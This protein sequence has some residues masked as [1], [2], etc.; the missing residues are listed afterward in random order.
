MVDPHSPPL[1]PLSPH[2]QSCGSPDPKKKKAKQQQ[3]RHSA[4]ITNVSL[5]AGHPHSSQDSQYSSN[6]NNSSD[7]PYL[8][9]P[10]SPSSN[11]N[12]QRNLNKAKE[13]LASK[14]DLFK[15]KSINNHNTTTTTN[16]NNT[17][18]ANFNH[19]NTRSTSQPG[20][21]TPP[22]LPNKDTIWKTKMKQG[23]VCTE[24]DH[25][26]MALSQQQQSQQ[27][28][29]QQCQN[30]PPPQHPPAPQAQPQGGPGLAVVSVSSATLS[31]PTIT[32]ATAANAGD[33]F[34]D[35]TQDT[36]DTDYI[37]KKDLFMHAQVRQQQQKDTPPYD[38]PASLSPNTYPLTTLEQ[39]PSTSYRNSG[40]SSKDNRL[41]STMSQDLSRLSINSSLP[42]TD[43][44]ISGDDLSLQMEDVNDF[45]DGNSDSG[46]ARGVHGDGPSAK[47]ST[48]D[49]ESS[50]YDSG[51][52]IASVAPGARNF[53]GHALSVLGTPVPVRSSTI[54]SSVASA[55]AS[56]PVVGLGPGGGPQ[57]RPQN[58]PY[59]MVENKPMSVL[60]RIQQQQR[61]K[62][63]EQERLTG[64]ILPS[65]ASPSSFSPTTFSS[66]PSPAAS[67]SKF[68]NDNNDKSKKPALSSSHG[69]TIANNVAGG[70]GLAGRN[71]SRDH[72]SSHQ[73]TPQPISS[74]S[75]ASSVPPPSSVPQSQAFPPPAAT[76]AIE[77]DTL[78]QLLAL[79]PGSHRP[80]LPSQVEWER[81][82]EQLRQKR[83][84]DTLVSGAGGLQ[85]SSVGRQIS[86]S[87]RHTEDDI[88]SAKGKT[89][90]H[91]M[92]DMPKDQMSPEERDRRRGDQFQNPMLMSPS[93][94]N[95]IGGNN[96]GAGTT[97][98]L[99]AGAGGHAYKRRSGFEDREQLLQQLPIQRQPILE[100]QAMDTTS[101][102]LS[103]HNNRNNDISYATALEPKNARLTGTDVAGSNVNAYIRPVNRSS[104]VVNAVETMEESDKDVLDVAFD[105]MLASL[106][107]PESARAQLESLPKER[108]WSMLQSS[109]AN[110]TLYQMPH[111]IPPQLFIDALLD[112][113]TKKKR[114]S[115]DQFAFNSSN[116]SL[117]SYS[118]GNTGNNSKSAGL[119][120][121]VSV[122]SLTSFGGNDNNSSSSSS[123]FGTSPDTHSTFQ[124]LSSLLGGA[125]ASSK[126]EKRALEEREQVLKKLRVLIRNGSI[127]WTSEFIKAGGSLA[128][129]QF[130]Y[131]VQESDETKLGQRERL[132]HQ[133]IQC[134]KAIVSLEGGIESLVRERLFFSVIRTLAIYSAPVLSSTLSHK[135]STGRSK[136]GFF[137]GNRSGSGGRVSIL[138][139]GGKGR[140]RSSS[141]SKPAPTRLLP[142]SSNSSNVNDHQSS[143]APLSVEQI[144]TFSTAQ[145]SV[146]ILVVILARVPELRDQIL[147]ETV[148]DPSCRDDINHMV[149]LSPWK[150]SSAPEDEDKTFG[151]YTFSEWIAYLKEIIQ[152]CGID[153]TLTS[154]S[155]S[156]AFSTA[157][158]AG[159]TTNNTSA[160]LV[161]VGQGLSMLGAGSSGSLFDNIRKRR[162]SHAGAQNVVGSGMRFEP[163]EDREVLA[164]L[165]AHLE[166]VSKLVFDMHISTPG[167]AFAKSIKESQLVDHLERVRGIYIHNQDLSAQIEDLTIQ[168]SAVPCTTLLAASRLERDLPVIP[169][170]NPSYFTK[171]HFPQHQEQQQQPR[172]QQQQQQQKEREHVLDDTTLS[173]S[174]LP[175]PS[176]LMSTS[177]SV[178]I[179][180]FPFPSSTTPAPNHHQYQYLPPDA[181]HNAQVIPG[182]SDIPSRSGSLNS[183]ADGRHINNVDT[184]HGNG[185]GAGG[186]ANRP[187]NEGLGPL[188]RSNS[189]YKPSPS[190]LQSSSHQSTHHGAGRN[191]KS[192]V[193]SA[194]DINST[195]VRESGV[196][197]PLSSTATA[198]LIRPISVK[199]SSQDGAARA[200]NHNL[201]GAPFTQEP[202]YSNMM[203]HEREQQLVPTRVPSSGRRATIGDPAPAPL[204]GLAMHS[205]LFTSRLPFVPPKNRSRPSSMDAKGG[206]SVYADYTTVKLDQLQHTTRP[207]VNQGYSS[208][209]IT[210]PGTAN[211]IPSSF[212]DDMITPLLPRNSSNNSNSSVSTFGHGRRSSLNS[213]GHMLVK[214]HQNGNGGSTI[215]NSAAATVASMNRPL[216]GGHGYH[217]HSGDYGI[218]SISTCSSTTP[219]GFTATSNSSISTSPLSTQARKHSLLSTAAA[220]AA[221][222]ASSNS[223]PET[224][225][226]NFTPTNSSQPST[227]ITTALPP[228]M[229]QP[230][231][232]SSVKMIPIPLQKK[233]VHE[234]RDVDFD[235]R[236]QEDVQRMISSSASKAR[237]RQMENDKDSNSIH[238]THTNGPN[239]GSTIFNNGG[240]GGSNSNN[241]R[242]N[243]HSNL[244]ATDPK[245]L[246]A[247]IV[248]PDDISVKREQYLQN[249]LM[250]I[251]L[252]PLEGQQR[253][254]DT[255]TP[256]PKQGFKSGPV[257]PR[258]PS[259]ESEAPVASTP[260]SALSSEPTISPDA[261]V[262]TVNVKTLVREQTPKTNTT[263]TVTTTNV[264]SRLAQLSSAG[265]S[266]A[267]RSID[268][269]MPAGSTA[270]QSSSAGVGKT[271]ISD[272][273]KMFERN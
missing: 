222:T 127:R 15:S 59:Q 152:M 228:L 89:R 81:G 87:S 193:I 192:V 177:T 168:L 60:E 44:S 73:Q 99:G 175:T 18:S 238:S 214:S 8:P 119:W 182:A 243:S 36:V 104:I 146:N 273:I 232:P 41:V 221:L 142:G 9:V 195:D 6:T 137:S 68:N 55:S 250:N 245:V 141:I 103:Y 47:D 111:T 209:P 23:V 183:F 159:K 33:I 48:S 101:I 231:S 109:E 74:A 240:G 12:N 57:Q 46:N 38:R 256:E 153:T 121:Q 229:P 138:S 92:P 174:P 165:N 216:V 24:D 225:N 257:P 267:R 110:P 56:A 215:E 230:N 82:L 4:P 269:T 84:D 220:K 122:T 186:G 203:Q 65:A 2:L 223:N 213:A 7:H 90:R 105:E 80:R 158:A 118:S 49:L 112:Y 148:A 95:G 116:L 171:H 262:D 25:H 32:A 64:L 66:V 94:S 131:H 130:C 181:E 227:F 172:P 160:K 123:M 197:P 189:Q 69:L 54:G 194:H 244:L 96:S 27:H 191:R 133:A 204:T 29:G 37:Q 113:P 26:A 265:A 140:A 71:F 167:L 147:R 234:F 45:Y 258:L 264:V 21:P 272:R 246:E 83:K 78:D 3:H 210:V 63:M 157:T 76:T 176:S 200:R 14:M 188:A 205:N 43:T 132:L 30:P 79:T 67:F 51:A 247:P 114:S 139:G 161:S 77:S 53:S 115:R 98:G 50:R 212:K 28:Q 10:S 242:N 40:N 156:A 93:G 128:L 120:K 190:Q 196:I 75:S 271:K 42:D 201:Q 173:A 149:A 97:A 253:M 224:N 86:I 151:V 211:S 126:N 268:I 237:P 125:G 270:G 155:S 108:K 198:G 134:V 185:S 199:R 19:V 163:G 107:L 135:G 61:R 260:P 202:S 85:I 178:I 252:P 233:Q 206:N 180:S 235:A 226:G 106:S 13:M 20:F 70:G 169:P 124:H 72:L 129:L 136:S 166:L 154:T 164:Y 208:A 52:A 170:F 266:P 261:V 88:G 117:N 34:H 22:P 1:S 11:N 162:N 91:S 16:N 17:N 144:P 236:I 187:L 259:T 145:T 251:V 239:I 62:S 150:T 218:S 35:H 58:L 219:S 217:N 207:A 248:V 263:P 241:S 31:S 255:P 249:Q 143:S 102:P 179:S 254:H 39:R 184:V 100:S 5:P